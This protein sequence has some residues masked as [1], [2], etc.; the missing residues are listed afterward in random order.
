MDVFFWQD[1]PD[2][3]SVKDA[4]FS[5]VDAVFCCLPHGTT[6]VWIFLL[7]KFRLYLNMLKNKENWRG[8]HWTLTWDYKIIRRYDTYLLFLLIFYLYVFTQEI[9]K[10][11]PTGL[12]IVDLSAVLFIHNCFFTYLFISGV[13]KEKIFFYK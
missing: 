7:S 5:K 2:M 8:D 4:D 10:H 1:L 11:L 12:K 6:Q 3:V 9:I 13:S